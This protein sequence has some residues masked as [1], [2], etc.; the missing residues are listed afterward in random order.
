M[1]RLSTSPTSSCRPVELR[2]STKKSAGPPMAKDVCPASGW[3]LRTPGRLWSQRRLAS[4]RQL[5]AQPADVAR[6]HEQDQVALPHGLLQSRPRLGQVAGE[7]RARNSRRA[8]PAGV[9]LAGGVD[10][11]QD[12]LVRAAEGPGE[13]VPEGCPA[14]V[15]MWLEHQHQPLVR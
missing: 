4:F 11:G 6:A 3:S 7:A 15:A 10:L 14:G 12:Q 8:D 2:A 1:P 13:V 9:R 5:I